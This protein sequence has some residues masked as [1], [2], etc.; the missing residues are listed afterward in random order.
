MSLFKKKTCCC[1]N[2]AKTEPRCTEKL[3]AI[4]SI[5]VLGAGCAS[6]HKQYENAKEA[7]KELGIA[8]EVEYVTDMT[9]VMEY[10]VISMPAIVVNEKAVSAGKVLSVSDVKKVLDKSI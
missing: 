5:K 1:G 7:V 9:K 4:T 2:T 8:V 10:G 3:G 6:C